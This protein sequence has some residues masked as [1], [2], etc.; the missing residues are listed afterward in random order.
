[1]A[2]YYIDAMK[3]RSMRCPCRKKADPTA[4]ADCCQPFHLGLRQPPTAEA[5]MRSRFSAFA[6]QNAPYLLGSWHPSSRPARIAFTPGQQ[7]LQLEVLASHERG[8]AA[9]VE[10]IARSR[11]GGQRHELHEVSRFVRE[12]GRWHYVDGL[13]R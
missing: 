4:Y 11:Q 2:S 12:C 1:M 9:T 8:D 13:I 10:F 7:W 6:L 5:L 3:A